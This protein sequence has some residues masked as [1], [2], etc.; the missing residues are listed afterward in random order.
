MP[1]ATISQRVIA[2]RRLTT[3]PDQEPAPPDQE[4]ECN[5]Q[6]VEPAGQSHFN[7]DADEV[8]ASHDGEKSL[9]DNARAQLHQ[10]W[11][12][13]AGYQHVDRRMVET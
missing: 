12:V 3:L 9:G 6:P 1:P 13:G 8:A 7:R 2:G 5:R 4:I 10:E 11:G